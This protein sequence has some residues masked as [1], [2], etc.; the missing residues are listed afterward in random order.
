MRDT[1]S[2]RLT[3]LILVA[4]VF[5]AV[6]S[7]AAASP[8]ASGAGKP[9]LPDWANI[10][11]PV[12]EYPDHSIKD[13][14][15]AYREGVFHVFFSSFHESRGRIRC[16]VMKT[17]TRDFQ[18]YTPLQLIDDGADAGWIGMA[19][20]DVTEYGGAYYLT[21]NSWGDK[22]GM[23]NQLFF[24]TSDDL[25]NWGERKPLAANLTRGGRAI[26]AAITHDRGRVILI[27]KGDG[28]RTRIASAGK[29]DEKFKFIGAG[30]PSF[31]M[32][33]GKES[34][35]AHENFQFLKIDGKWMMLTT[36]YK[37]QEPFVYELAGNGESPADWLKWINGRKVEIPLL[38]FN[39]KDRANGSAALDMRSEDGNFY[40]FFAGNTEYD[41]FLGRGWNCMG[42]AKSPD[43]MRWETAEN[44]K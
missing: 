29:P 35:L 7:I 43:F 36:D 39:T 22:P 37:P 44:K 1:N 34:S 27:W 2:K 33:D 28:F 25:E 15:V 8:G 23:P 14:A 12:L 32:P 11:N 16:H 19:S 4:A 5:I 40:L 13:F 24:R 41:T 21:Y 10:R 20:P 6:N 17:T 30:Y 18:T 42:I 38:G 9:Q 3:D 31:K 26:D